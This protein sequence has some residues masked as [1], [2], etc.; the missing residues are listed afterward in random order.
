MSTPSPPPLNP[1]LDLQDFYRF[2]VPAL[3]GVSEKRALF[4]VFLETLRDPNLTGEHKVKCLSLVVIPVLTTTLEDPHT[5]NAEVVTDSLV[6]DIFVYSARRTLFFFSL[7]SRSMIPLVGIQ[8]RADA[9]A[10]TPI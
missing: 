3:A 10:G 9:L 2:E 6:S 7:C 8:I 5:N 1:I 4:R